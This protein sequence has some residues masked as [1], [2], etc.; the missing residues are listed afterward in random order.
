M[1]GGSIT[2]ARAALGAAAVVAAAAIGIALTRGDETAAPASPAGTPSAP[3]A[4]SGADMIAQLEARVRETPADPNG[5]RLLGWATFEAGRYRESAD[6]YRR[7]AELAPDK[8]D[9]WSA[10]G[11]ATVLAERD[12]VSPRAEAA[13]RRAL[14]VD[15]ANARARYFLGVKKDLA[16]D[17]KG[18]V[19]DWIALLKDGPAD[20]AWAPDVRRLVQKIAAD[21]GI[22]I[23][24]RLPPAPASAGPTPD[25]VQAAATMPTAQQAEMIRGMVDGLAARLAESPQDP[26]GWIRLMRAR[27]VLNDP[28]GAARALQQA[29]AANPDARQSLDDAARTLG[30]PTG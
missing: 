29:R 12:G 24:G 27:M 19:E 25:Q 10:L 7:A 21:N 15:P 16:G 2:P 23:E 11:E 28:A 20:A 3:A 13:F 6:A 1:A 8:A 22:P 26:E 18:A 5:W 30:I 14:A 17:H 4:Q 9:Y